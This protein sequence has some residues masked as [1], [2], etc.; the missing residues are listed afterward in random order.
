MNS[1]SIG[2]LYLYIYIVPSSLLA[3]VKTELSVPWH[4][5][6]LNQNI[7][8]KSTISRNSAAI[9]TCVSSDSYQHVLVS[10]YTW[11]GIRLLL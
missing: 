8:V 9:G 10:H 3:Q 11:C 2:N 5:E 6:G 1:M 4:I 7:W